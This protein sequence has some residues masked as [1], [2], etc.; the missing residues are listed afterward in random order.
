M[1]LRCRE[2][3]RKRPDR[4]CGGLV[5]WIPDD[6]VVEKVVER[7][8]DSGNAYAKMCPSCKRVHVI[9]LAR[10]TRSA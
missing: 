2:P 4:E 5:G 6:A 10:L 9:R 3:D 1:K 7:F 8:D